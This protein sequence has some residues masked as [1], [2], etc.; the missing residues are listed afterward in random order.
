MSFRVVW[1]WNLMVSEIFWKSI[2]RGS[3]L[4]GMTLEWD[5]SHFGAIPRWTFFKKTSILWKPDVNFVKFLFAYY[6]VRHHLQ[7]SSPIHYQPP[8]GSVWIAT[9]I[10]QS[11]PNPPTY[12]P[13]YIYLHVMHTAKTFLSCSLPKAMDISRVKLAGEKINKLG[14]SYPSVI[15]WSEISGGQKQKVA[16]QKREIKDSEVV[17]L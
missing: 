5:I 11:T 7:S 10:I 3:F 14:E 9:S 4:A 1:N 17:S 6:W 16:S 13:Q 2:I 12:C 8:S 15:S